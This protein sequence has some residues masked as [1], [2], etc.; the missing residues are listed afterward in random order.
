MTRK[1]EI[2]NQLTGMLEEAATWAE[3]QVLR[4][5]IRDDYIRSIEG[6]FAIS[7][8][9]EN[10]DGSWTQALADSNGDPIQP[11]EDS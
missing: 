7:V 6:V 4:D 11:A 10:E 5:R 1:Y 2:H 9:T 3:A 8:L